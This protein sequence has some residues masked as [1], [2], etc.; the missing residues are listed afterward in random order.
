MAKSAV[1]LDD[2]MSLDDLKAANAAA[3]KAET[4]AAQ[5]DENKSDEKDLDGSPQDADNENDA[6]E[7]KDN[8]GDIGEGA[9]P[10]PDETGDAELE[11]WMRGD[12][13]TPEAEKEFTSKDMA[14][15]RHKY[16]SKLADTKTELDDI[17]AELEALKNKPAAGQPQQLVRPKRDDFFDN[18]DPEGAYDEAFSEFILKKA[19]AQM[20]AQTASTNQ[21]RAQQQAAEKI[22]KDEEAHYDRVAKLVA[23]SGI[24]PDLY[25]SADRA[26]REAIDAAIPGSGDNIAAVFMGKMGEGSEKVV[27][28]IGINSAKKAKLTQL[29]LDDPTGLDAGMYMA[30]LKSSVLS[31]NK[32]QSRAPKPAPETKGDAK[33]SGK[34]KSL[35]KLYQ[36]STN[37]QDRMDIVGRAKAAGIGIK[38]TLS[39]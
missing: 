28:S 11:D 22:S 37:Q 14:A 17:K 12:A 31:S 36:S 6:G 10:K 39:W 26:F 34:F 18:D 32:K 9:E 27:Y 20:A 8:P 16:K 3:E 19:E 23:D 13:D 4:N 7:G 5:T 1:I 2:G 15:Q 25:Q 33:E 29:L 38:E 24:K 21:Q 30:E 35:K